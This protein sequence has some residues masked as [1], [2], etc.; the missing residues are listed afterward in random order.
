MRI[1]ICLAGCFRSYDTQIHQHLYE[2]FYSQYECDIFAHTWNYRDIDRHGQVSER[3][4]HPLHVMKEEFHF[5]DVMIEDWELFVSR[6]IDEAQIIRHLR[7]MED[8]G[9]IH[10]GYGHHHNIYLTA[11]ALAMYYSR[12]KAGELLQ[13]HMQRTGTVYDRIVFTRFDQTLILQPKLHELDPT[14]L[15]LPFEHGDTIQIPTP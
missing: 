8:G 15:Y 12:W 1:A 3:I 4:P 10:L 13:V 2:Q 5:T 9:G 7:W 6:F 11:R 14:K